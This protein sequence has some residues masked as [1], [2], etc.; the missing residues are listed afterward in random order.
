MNLV[1]ISWS[2]NWNSDSQLS[3]GT[4]K[5]EENVIMVFLQSVLPSFWIRKT[6]RRLSS[7]DF[8]ENYLKSIE[9]FSN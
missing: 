9:C 5:S 2:H 3:I 7:L 6:I 8:R 4:L 1:L